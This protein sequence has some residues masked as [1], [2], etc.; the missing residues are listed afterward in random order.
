MWVCSMH[1]EMNYAQLLLGKLEQKDRLEDPGIEG[2]II[3][4]LILKKR[5]GRHGWD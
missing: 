4:K 5:D 1:R 3:L 2:W